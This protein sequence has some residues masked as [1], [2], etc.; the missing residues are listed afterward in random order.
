MHSGIAGIDKT[1]FKL[2]MGDNQTLVEEEL[3]G[4]LIRDAVLE[5]EEPSNRHDTHLPSFLLWNMNL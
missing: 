4:D 1:A 5:I 3:P 2:R